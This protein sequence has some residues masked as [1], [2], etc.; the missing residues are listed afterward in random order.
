MPDSK[1][2]DQQAKDHGN[3][4]DEGVAEVEKEAG[5]AADKAAA[6][7]R[8]PDHGLIDEV[9]DGHEKEADREHGGEGSGQ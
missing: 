5:K 9:A 6:L 4:M 8:G 3:L 2:I 1:D 7:T